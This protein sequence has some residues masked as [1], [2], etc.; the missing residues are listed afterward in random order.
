MHHI[1]PSVDYAMFYPALQSPEGEEIRDAQGKV[2][3][4][5]HVV[6]VREPVQY[7]YHDLHTSVSEYLDAIVAM[8][9]GLSRI[10][11]LRR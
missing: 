5:H 4:R 11:V 2:I 3:G 10:A 9:E 7:A 6:R 1:R 8:L